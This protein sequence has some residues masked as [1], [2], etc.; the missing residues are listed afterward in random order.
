M[1]KIT[2]K[3]CPMVFAADTGRELALGQSRAV[4]PILHIAPARAAANEGVTGALCG[5]T[6]QIRLALS[7]LNAYHRAASGA[8]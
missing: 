2:L 7:E 6:T 3:L 5:F 1:I 4:V 8:A